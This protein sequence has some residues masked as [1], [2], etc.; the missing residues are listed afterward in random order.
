M[1]GSVPE[2][3]KQNQRRGKTSENIDLPANTELTLPSQIALLQAPDAKPNK[4]NQIYLRGGVIHGVIYTLAREK[5]WSGP[6]VLLDEDVAMEGFIYTP[7]GI[8]RPSYRSRYRR[9]LTCS[10][11]LH[12]L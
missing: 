1:A 10:L 6:L 11:R 2:S 9:N 3:L 8:G 12:D 7:L 4:S 5:T